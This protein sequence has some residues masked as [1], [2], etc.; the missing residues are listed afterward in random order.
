M[1]KQ[2]PSVFVSHSDRDSALAR[3][4]A[5][6][7]ESHGLRPVLL[8]E[9]N[10]PAGKDVWSAVESAIAGCDAYLVLVGSEGEPSRWQQ[11][12]WSVAL[13]SC[14][15]DETKRLEPVVRQGAPIP[16]FLRGRT[17]I[18][19]P[20]DD[21]SEGEWETW[22]GEVAARIRRGEE[23]ED[24]SPWAARARAER[25]SRLR[26]LEVEVAELSKAADEPGSA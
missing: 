15:R 9:G 2:A 7:L 14:W 1:G 26:E 11:A 4:I 5:S 17:W 13:E 22:L 8:D 3:R 23:G 18:R 24:S 20:S 21:A 16:P 25:L 6:G 12:E 10:L 19:P